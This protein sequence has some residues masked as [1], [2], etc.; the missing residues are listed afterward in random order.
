MITVIRYISNSLMFVETSFIRRKNKIQ[1]QR[2]LKTK[3]LEINNPAIYGFIFKNYFKFNC[4]KMRFFCTNIL[5]LCR[6]ILMI[7]VK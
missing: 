7:N 3:Y 1:F 6:F 5:L 4:K 2:T